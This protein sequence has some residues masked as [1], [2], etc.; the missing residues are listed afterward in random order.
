MLMHSRQKRSITIMHKR[1][2]KQFA[3]AT[4]LASQHVALDALQAAI[5]ELEEAVEAA[6]R[7]SE[8]ARRQ[9]GR[10]DPTS[11][12]GKIEAAR[13]NQDQLLKIRIE[14]DE[15]AISYMTSFLIWDV[16][17]ERMM[18]GRKNL[19]DAIGA[20]LAALDTIPEKGDEIARALRLSFKAEIVRASRAHRLEVEWIDSHDTLLQR[21]K[22]V[23]AAA[24]RK[25]KATVKSNLKNPYTT[26]LV[27][28][29]RAVL[30]HLNP[31]VDLRRVWAVEFSD[32][33]KNPSSTRLFQLL[34]L[35]E[36]KLQTCRQAENALRSDQNGRINERQHASRMLD[37]LHN[38]DSADAAY[39]CGG[40]L[41]QQV[42]AQNER[43]FQYETYRLG[44]TIATR[45]LRHVLTQIVHALLGS[46]EEAETELRKVEEVRPATL[47][48]N[49]WIMLNNC[50]AADLQLRRMVRE[51]NGFEASLNND[52]SKGAGR[53]AVD[54]EF[55]AVEQSYSYLRA[56][57]APAT[58][59]GDAQ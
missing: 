46:V 59:S 17:R 40:T 53:R 11:W 8:D 2:N 55:A 19:S 27:V 18:N 13:Q 41:D 58:E 22:I 56:R 35:A 38:D 26:D 36:E 5:A 25:L 51:L 37:F 20:A 12:S 14:Y 39:R 42:A 23:Q 50:L 33:E 48:S 31:D 47:V 3:P 28:N 44:L 54:E 1:Q 57:T 45:G 32:E 29:G 52:L 6:Q 30:T 4:L 49:V 9:A 24:F 15:E 34:K 43:R 16:A 10:V 7:A 21:L